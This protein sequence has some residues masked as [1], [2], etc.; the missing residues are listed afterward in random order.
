VATTT[1]PTGLLHTL[2][3]WALHRGITLEGLSVVRPSLEDIY[4]EL[5]AAQDES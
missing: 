1:E 5:I 4:L 3:G 2:T